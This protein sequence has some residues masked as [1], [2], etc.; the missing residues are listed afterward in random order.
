MN[1]D[2]EKAKKHIT[3]W[4]PQVQLAIDK[5]NHLLPIGENHNK[6]CPSFTPQYDTYDNKYEHSENEEGLA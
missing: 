3:E 2:N 6:V 1:A 4:R 5:L